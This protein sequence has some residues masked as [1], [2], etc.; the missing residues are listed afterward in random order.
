M[1]ISRY[2]YYGALCVFFAGTL[3]VLAD[4]RTD[5][6]IR[7]LK[8]SP[9]FRVR[10]QA[11]LSLGASQ[12]QTDAV[13]AL[14][15]ALKDSN[16]IVRAAAASSLEQLGNPTALPALEQAKRDTDATVRRTVAKSIEALTRIAR[17]SRSRPST[18][19][20]PSVPARYYVGLGQLA[21]A[22]SIRVPSTVMNETQTFF[23]DTVRDTPTILLAPKNEN[24]REA[25]RILR[26]KGMVGFYVDASITQL[27]VTPQGG[28]QEV[29]AEVSLTLQTY[30]ERDIKAILPG[31][32]TIRGARGDEAIRLALRAA[33]RAA[34]R[35]L[36]SALG[37]LETS[38]P[39][40]SSRTKRSRT[41]QR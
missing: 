14:S 24:V 5:Y 39:P 4:S 6:L 30:P 18:T 13:A 8:T 31:N 29:Y 7:L 17:A 40:P 22:T 27:R 36:E 32:A 21:T 1:F 35:G 41:R 34:L 2:R 28:T 16:P 33:T 12:S 26:D 38:G 19:A 23:Q 10:A 25:Y 9:Q 3:T 37:Q 11:A 20:Q 15:Q